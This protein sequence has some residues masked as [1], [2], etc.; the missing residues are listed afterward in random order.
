MAS[1]SRMVR[2]EFLLETA[3]EIEALEAK[4]KELDERELALINSIAEFL[5]GSGVSSSEIMAKAVTERFIKMA[6]RQEL[7]TDK[8]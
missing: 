2:W 1:E 6:G 3:K 7:T 8:G 5:K 4:V